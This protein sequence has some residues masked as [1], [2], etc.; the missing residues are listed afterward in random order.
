MN[1]HTHTMGQR[2]TRIFFNYYY[3]YYRILC[4]SLC[5]LFDGKNVRNYARYLSIEKKRAT[6]SEVLVLVRIFNSIQKRKVLHLLAT[7]HGVE[8]FTQR[9]LVKLFAFLPS[10]FCII[11]IFRGRHDIQSCVTLR[12]RR[13]MGKSFPLVA[14]GAMR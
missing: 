3:Y 8:N 2:T 4:A 7:Q 5:L 1:R 13:A 12:G 10:N 6:T 9:L 14:A 11:N